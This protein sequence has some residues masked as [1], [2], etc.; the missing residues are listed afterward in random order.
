MIFRIKLKCIVT[1]CRNQGHKLSLYKQRITISLLSQWS[2]IITQVRW[3]DTDMAKG[4][5]PSIPRTNDLLL[6]RLKSV[7]ESSDHE[8]SQKIS[9]NQVYSP[10]LSFLS[11]SPSPYFPPTKHSSLP[12]FLPLASHFS[13]EKSISDK[14]RNTCFQPNL[15]LSPS[16]DLLKA[17]MHGD[18]KLNSQD[19][20]DNMHQ[21]NCISPIPQNKHKHTF[22]T[23]INEYKEI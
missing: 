14:P 6:W 20:Y 21:N 8:I 18:S 19:N 3:V 1:G 4:D 23:N 17:S 15:L 10:S 2:C 13:P 7:I 16:T 11:I 12:Y 5:G 9:L 22:Y